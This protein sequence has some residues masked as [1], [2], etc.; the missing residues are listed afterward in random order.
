MELVGSTVDQRVTRIAGR[1]EEQRLLGEAIRGASG[2]SPCAV[3]VHGE[4]GVGKTRL[5][6]QVCADAELRGFTTLWG[7]CVHFGAASSS[8]LPIISALERWLASAPAAER[9]RLLGEM[10]ALEEL[11]PSL[12]GSTSVE[13][14]GRPLSILDTAIDKISLRRPTI[15]VIDDMQ[16]ADVTS[17]DVLAY[18][19]TGFRG[20][21]LALLTTYRDEG[22]DD[23]HPLHGWLADMLRTP[24]VTDLALQRMSLDE[25]EQQISLLTGTTPSRGLLDDVMAQSRGNS[26]LTEL[27]VRDVGPDSKSLPRGLP[28][29]LRA[30]LLAAWH[31]LNPS[32]RDV[33][34]M[35]AVGGRPLVFDDL[36]RVLAGN[37]VDARAAAVALSEAIKAGVVQTDSSGEFW[38]R[39][40]LLAE[41]LCDTLLPGEAKPLHA[42][43]ADALA[44]GNVG[45]HK[46][47]A[48]LALHCERADRVDDAFGH[49]LAAAEQAQRVHGFPEQMR[50]LLRAAKLWGVV[51]PATRTAAGAES[52]PRLW[53][54]VA[55]VARSASDADQAFAAIDHARGLIDETTEP[56]VAS[57]VC[58]LWGEMATF[59]GRVA[60]QPIESFQEAVS[61]AAEFPDSI[62]YVRALAAL[63]EA[64]AWS[65]QHEPAVRNAQAAVAAA[66]RSGE[67]RTRSLALQ[68]RSLAHIDEPSGVAD[69]EEAY[70]LAMESGDR[71][72]IATACITR[73]NYYEERGQPR[74][75]ADLYLDSVRSSFGSKAGVEMFHAAY[76][77]YYLLMLG[78][79]PAARAMLREPL[80]A[81]ATGSAGLQAREVA[82]QVA[83]RQGRIEEAEGHLLRA[84]EIAPDFEHHAGLHGP[85]AYAEYLVAIEKPREALD[86]LL[87]EIEAHGRAEPRYADMLLTYGA[88]AAA[89]MAEAARD[90]DGAGSGAGGSDDA[91]GAHGSDGAGG[92]GG[93]GPAPTAESLLEQLVVLR[94]SLP[95]EPFERHD[96]G[97]LVQPAVRA[98]YEAE[99]A[100]CLGDKAGLPDLWLAAARACAA[101]E[102]A[103]H[104][105][106]AW[107]RHAQALLSAGAGRAQV[108]AALRAAHQIALRIEAEPLRRAVEGL[109]VSARISLALP[110][111]PAQGA[112]HPGLRGL[113]ALTRRE[114]EVLGHLVAGRSYTEIASALYI[115]DKTVSVHVSNLLRKTGSTNRV[116]A[117]E[118]ARRHGLHAAE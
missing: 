61:L 80:A 14:G 81:R 30:A 6:R 1:V 111:V 37:G 62:E 105:A 112:P 35:L 99:R 56:L 110:V 48:D 115:S 76:G 44:A 29:A 5:V 69:A 23:G 45:G 118:L 106:I 25:T 42:L 18:L 73:A 15:L 24:M 93:A 72:H 75:A 66:D 12:G 55:S 89:D 22:L 91:D 88:H 83:L 46:L 43:F 51:C 21:R 9:D 78:E 95:R 68:A 16:W 34:R 57:R 4:A 85:S 41:V 54:D 82:A 52:E 10:G 71:R 92:A 96:D 49:Y 28:D 102:M 3:F 64:Q 84:R 27:L 19:V 86:L 20:Q 13:S 103:W 116:E 98:F 90:A 60:E 113:P 94:R 87:R 114:M 70:R 36:E 47:R 74:R 67:L 7:R 2:R 101:G 107:H 59:A 117:A 17:L 39:H 58:Q 104:E 26:Y 97:D 50:A 33:V 11:L 40:P 38:F 8:Y 31:R 63:S 100:R 65:G 108:V 79:L 77:A 109:A 53:S 32:T